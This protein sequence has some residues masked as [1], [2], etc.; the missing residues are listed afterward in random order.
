MRILGLIPARAGSKGV[1][2][3]NIKLLNGKPLLN[4]TT[5]V[6]LKCEFIHKVVL[7][8]EDQENISAGRKSGVDVPFVRPKELAQDHTP[9]LPVVL[10]ALEFFEHRGVHF[11]AV[12][13][14]QVTT[15]FRTVD[16]LNKSIS[17]FIKSG[18]DSLIS[19]R[20]VPHQYNPHWTF[21]MDESGLLKISTGEK[22]II[23]RR[24]ELPDA[25]HRDGSIYL[26]KVEVLKEQ[27]SLF[28]D[29]ISFMISPESFNI[30][31]DTQEDWA[32]A[33]Q[34]AVDWNPFA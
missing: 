4:Y 18:A 19:V 1:P 3:K 16:F 28:G 2:G 12:C 22:R 5:E 6:A 13:L 8:S 24:Q 10:H 29:T 32:I 33:E 15:P 17:K 25:F 30:N 7:S 11:D 9:T 20:R 21:E 23:S 31:I 14:L 26:T 34:L 27:N